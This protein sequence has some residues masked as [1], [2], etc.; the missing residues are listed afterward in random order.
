MILPGAGFGITGQLRRTQRAGLL[1]TE[2]R[3]NKDSLCL[4]ASSWLTKRVRD[5]NM[6][7]HMLL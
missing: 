6:I 3:K 7:M 4:E 2:G 5:M 1:S